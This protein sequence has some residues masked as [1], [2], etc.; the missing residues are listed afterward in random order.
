MARHIGKFR[1]RPIDQLRSRADGGA[2]PCVSLP[3]PF[4]PSAGAS[5]RIFE[6]GKSSAVWPTFSQN[7]LKIEKRPD[8]G[9]FI[10]ESGGRPLRGTGKI[11]ISEHWG[12]PSPR[13]RR[14]WPSVVSLL[15]A[16]G[17]GDDTTTRVAPL[18]WREGG[19]MIMFA[20]PYRRCDA[21][22]AAFGWDGTGH[23]EGVFGGGAEEGRRW[24]TCTLYSCTHKNG[25]SGVSCVCVWGGGKQGYL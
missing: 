8:L 3:A 2:S 11:L 13:F 23:G 24:E 14:P 17:D 5:P 25:P 16:A 10:L 1:R 19:A 20:L 7:T 21:S 15:T 22:A 4:S 12:P 9:H 6:G 18:Q